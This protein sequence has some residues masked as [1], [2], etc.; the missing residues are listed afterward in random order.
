MMD[1]LYQ[2]PLFEGVSDDEIRWLIDHSHEETL[3]DGDFFFRENGPADRFCIVLEGELQVSRTVDG[4]EIIMGTTPRGIMGGEIPLLNRIPANIN[5]RAI[6]PCRL[7]VFDEQAFR[8]I[9]TA[10]PVVGMRILQTATER[11]Q[12]TASI[13]KQQEKMAALGK[14]AAG[15]A[16]ELNNPA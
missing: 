14:L 11:M 8:E 5:A 4:R 12:R 9:F 6:M 1:A 13:L 10:C 2:F 7:M 15:L 3:Q 16:H